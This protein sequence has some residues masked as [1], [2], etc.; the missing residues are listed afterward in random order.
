MR[1]IAQ[2]VDW[3]TTPYTIYLITKDPTVSPSVKIRAIVGLVAIFAYV[4]SPI[5]IIPDFIPF[6]G[7]VDDLIIVPLG[8]VLVREF[9]PG[10]DV[11]DKRNMAQ[12][13]IKRV[14]F[15]VI[16]IFAAAILL[17]LLLLGLLIY[18]LVRSIPIR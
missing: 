12:V 1:F 16:L 13:S 8:I 11:I 17:G 4:V 3:V 2:I 7:W 6:S 14:L 9:T 15:R 5:D 18:V 10:I